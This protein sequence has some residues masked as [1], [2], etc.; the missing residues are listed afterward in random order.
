MYCAHCG[1]K[2]T[3]G[4]L[5][6]PFCGKEIQIPEQ[7]PE[8]DETVRTR[9]EMERAA[10]EFVPLDIDSGWD[11]EQHKPA[12]SEEEDLGWDRPAPKQE[13]PAEPTPARPAQP[14]PRTYV[15]ETPRVP[16]TRA[17]QKQFDPDNIFM[18][19]RA[20]AAAKPVRR[21]RRND[22]QGFVVRH[23][24]GLVALGL[25][26]LVAAILAGWLFSD[27]G[28]MAL[29]KHGL[30]WR[31]TAYE[32]LGAT[33]YSAAEYLA[34]GHYYD[35]AI[36]QEETVD[37]LIS[38]AISYVRGGD[39]E[40]AEQRARRAIDLSDGDPRGYQILQQLYPDATTRPQAVASLI[41]HGYAVTGDASL[42][43][44]TEN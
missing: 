11:G 29:G 6:C 36:E 27:M 17:P 33:A 21:R 30:A 13:R 44:S 39:S 26:V 5:F 34:A 23:L 7:D 14:R 19:S 28:Q 41:Q 12:G 20:E 16:D 37:R 35:R 40:R 9:Q 15:P 4:M 18:E 24:R 8:S 31:P 22:E 10:A 42:A 43:P 32:R 2:V 3:D 1:K 25:L 38:S